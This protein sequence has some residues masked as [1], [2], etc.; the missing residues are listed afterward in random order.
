VFYLNVAKVDLDVAYTC[1]LQAY[2]SSV[3]GVS[4]VCCKCF[5]WMLHI[6]AMATH[7]FSWC[8]RRMLQVFQLFRT[9]VASIYWDVVKVDLV[10]YI[11]QWDPPTVATCY[12]CWACVYVCGSEGGTS[13]RRG[14]LSRRKSRRGPHMG[15]CRRG[16]RSSVAV[17]KAQQHAYVQ[18]SGCPGAGLTDWGKGDSAG[19]R[20]VNQSENG[21]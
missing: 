21:E 9:Y 7:M 1:I 14:K 2:V 12:I 19:T 5:I 20:L 15:V 11:L 8:F 13:G 16:K 18:V 6:F 4:Y 10:L 17:K 3:S